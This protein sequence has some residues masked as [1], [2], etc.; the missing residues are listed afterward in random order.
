MRTFVLRLSRPLLVVAA[1]DSLLAG[2]WALAYPAGLFA[3]L[4]M[5]P[6]RDAFL[7]QVLG[8][9]SLAHALCLALAAWRPGDYAG[10][11]LVPLIGRAL[12]C[13]LWLWLLGTDRVLLPA[14]PLTGLLVHDAVWLPLFAAFLFAARR[15]CDGRRSCPDAG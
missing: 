3:L 7:W 15:A 4:G 12:Q 10:L 6:P 9:L 13:G 5:T 8:G 14:G 11:V 2:V 1:L